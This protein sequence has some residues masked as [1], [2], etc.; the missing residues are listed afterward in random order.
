MTP[1]VEMTLQDRGSA[2]P[3]ERAES[4]G[5]VVLRSVRRAYGGVVAVDDV[6]LNVAEGE[7]FALLGPSG[8]GKSTT[9]R[10]IAGLDLPD[11]GEIRIGGRAMTNVP[12]HKRPVNTVFQQYALFPHLTVYDN[13]AFGLREARVRRSE[14]RTRVARMLG[15]VNLVGRENA[16][17]RHL[18]GGMQQR[19]A[20][21][22]AL[23][24]EPRVLLLDEPLAALDRK[25]RSQMQESIKD[26]QRKVGTTFVFVTHDQEEAFSMADRVAVMNMGHIEQIGE[27][28]TIYERPES[29]FVADFVGVSNKIRARV[30]DSMGAGRYRAE[31]ESVG[32]VHAEGVRGLRPG[33][34]TFLILRPEVME[35]HAAPTERRGI[36]GSV[37]DVSYLGPQVVYR[38][39]TESV[40]EIHVIAPGRFQQNASMG[41]RVSVRWEADSGWLLPAAS[42]SD[43]APATAT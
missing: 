12:A 33:D 10:L 19:V 23:V 17:P 8:C 25:L 7:F 39:S 41:D 24:L 18:S 26:I 21:A 37:T 34:A 38:V 16:K 29:L 3:A 42:S 36:H 32:V 5:A 1:E 31:V 9:L 20:L 4:S 13:V 2:R 35:L 40:G 27:P 22:R 30:T 11:S 28:K 15:L 14:I 6:D 43:E